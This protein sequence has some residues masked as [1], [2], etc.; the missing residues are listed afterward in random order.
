MMAGTGSGRDRWFFVLHFPLQC[1]VDCSC[2]LPPVLECEKC[3]CNATGFVSCA[4][5]S[6]SVDSVAYSRVGAYRADVRACAGYRSESPVVGPEQ[7]QI[8]RTTG[9]S[10]AGD[11]LPG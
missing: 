1:S 3:T 4:R 8:T 9:I 10:A 2:W 6:R 11:S 5:P 7:C